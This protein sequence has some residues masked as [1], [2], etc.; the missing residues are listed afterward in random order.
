MIIPVPDCQETRFDTRG[1]CHGNDAQY[2]TLSPGVVQDTP[3]GHVVTLCGSH[4]RMAGAH[5]EIRKAER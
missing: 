1:D 3:A 4:A 2:V 5:G